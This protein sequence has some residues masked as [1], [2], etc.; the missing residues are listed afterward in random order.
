LVRWL[1]AFRVQATGLGQAGVPNNAP[2]RNA[3]ELAP[4]ESR[5][6]YRLAD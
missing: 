6:G 4:P 5:L 1:R 3:S 2:S